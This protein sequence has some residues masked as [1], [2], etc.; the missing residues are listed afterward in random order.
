MLMSALAIIHALLLW[1]LWWIFILCSS[2]FQRLHKIV[3]LIIKRGR[4]G[5][6]RKQCC[7]NNKMSN[8]G[9]CIVCRCGSFFKKCYIDLSVICGLQDWFAKNCH[10]EKPGHSIVIVNYNKLK[11]H[12]QNA[13]RTI[14]NKKSM[15]RQFKLARSR[16]SWV[17]Q[18][19]L[20]SSFMKQS[21][22]SECWLKCISHMSI[23]KLYYICVSA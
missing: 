21:L 19:Q 3:L 11:D 8:R 13:G 23:N 22:L 18:S 10:F 16:I 1:F 2:P 4:K 15:E 17:G 5:L 20:F 9:G 12:R 14:M 7:V 6:V